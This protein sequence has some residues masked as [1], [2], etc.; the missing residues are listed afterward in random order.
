MEF[1]SRQQ[2]FEILLTFLNAA[3]ETGIPKIQDFNT[4]DNFGIGYFQFTTSRNKLLK[5]RCSA[6]KGYLKPAKKRSNLKVVV[7]AF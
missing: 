2:H 4:G 3:E 7:E 5:L 1:L 6:A